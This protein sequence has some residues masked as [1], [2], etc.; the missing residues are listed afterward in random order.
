MSGIAANQQATY[1]ARI[2]DQNKVMAQNASAD[3]LDRGRIAATQQ[4]RH[5][6]ALKG[7]QNAAMAANGV[8]T[9]FGSAADLVGDT[10]MI[11]SQDALTVRENARRESM[12]Y[13]I[14]GYN[15]DAK[16]RGARATAKNALIAT[17]FDVA[18][19]ALGG[20]SQTSKLKAGGY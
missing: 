1:Q 14:E 18:S 13:A 4:Y 5:N 20:A 9:S 7:E 17:A 11:T 12:G 16:A 19:T 6:A 2:A 15:Y 10:A 3:A 8:D